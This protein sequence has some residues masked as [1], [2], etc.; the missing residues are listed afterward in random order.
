MRRRVLLLALAL[1]IGAC[2]SEGTAPSP[3]PSSPASGA[4]AA[5]ASSVTAAAAGMADLR[6]LVTRADSGADIAGARVCASR[7]S[8]SPLCTESRADGVATL[9]GP[10]GTY[11]LTVTGPSAQRWEPQTRVAD[12][13]GGTVA[14]WL[15]LEELHRISGRIRDAAERAVAGAEACAHPT[16]DAPQVCAR[17]GSDGLYF[18]DVKSGTYRVEVAGPPGGRLVSQWARGRVFLE[19]AD[20]V[21]ARTAD[22]PDVDVTLASGVVLRGTVTLAGAPVED[23]QVCIRTLAAPLP[24][25]CERTDKKGAY[26]ALREP[27]SYYVWTVPPANMRAIPQ[28][29]DRATTGVGSSPLRLD[30]DVTL[31]VALRSGAQLRGTVRADDGRIV[32]GALVC[33]DTP[34]AS[35]R[36]C[37]ETD[38]N[39]SYTI[40]TRPETYIVSVYPPDHSALIAGYWNGKRNWTD[41]DEIV[42]GTTDRT[43]DLVVTSG[44]RVAGVVRNAR[45]IPVAGATID[46]SDR[47]GVVAA[48]DTNASGRFETVVRGGHYTIEVFPPFVGNLIGRVFELDIPTARDLEVTLSDVTP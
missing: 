13:S 47:S 26:A 35:G 38:G 6:V 2:S 44:V 24:W 46:L 36:I 32:Q 27:G 23:A 48:T 18:I 25:Q 11:F 17:S 39:G 21:D 33:I 14:M 20:V 9:S 37:R 22:V 40:T 31:D 3:V 4:S 34:F 28:W 8:G 15:Q 29:Y 45:G 43:L 5:T 12:A 1:L 41:A 10:R 7:T 30:G 42:I 19:E 16:S